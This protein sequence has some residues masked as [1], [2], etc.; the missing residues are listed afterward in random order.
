MRYV[1]LFAVAVVMLCG[2]FP[3][4]LDAQTSPKASPPPGATQAAAKSTPAAAS[5]RLSFAVS[6]G[7]SGGIDPSQAI[8]KYRPLADLMEKA[9]GKQII[10]SLV[11]S[12][13]A[14]E[15]GLKNDE[16]DLVIARPSDYPARGIRD[17]RYS[18][19]ATS[20]PD[21]RCVFIVEKNA[22]LKTVADIKGKNVMLPEKISYMSKFCSAELRDKG[23][24]VAT[25]KVIYTKE[26]GAVGWSVENRAA[27]V[28]AVASYS[29]V[30]KNWE[31]SGHRILHNSA[32]QPY[33]PLIASA[34]VS[35]ELLAKL[36]AVLGDLDKTEAGQK[37]L[38]SAGIQGFNLESSA[39]LLALLAWLE[40]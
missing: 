9:L 29:A 7:T 16:F 35:P 10:V 39:R 13:E 34:R 19:V 22:T 20:K 32:P 2:L 30:A 12:F 15:T 28:G 6:E 27:D 40:K 33:S 37:A 8:A 21:G 3:I 17:Y 4:G 25:E 24:N 38:A 11:R 23:I 31:K 26:Q 18:L 14:L 36:K 5:N 1:N